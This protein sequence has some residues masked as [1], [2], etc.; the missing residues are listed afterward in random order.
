[1]TVAHALSGGLRDVFRAPALILAAVVAMLVMAVPFGMTVGARVQQSLAHRQPVAHGA[2][3]IDAEWW[4]QFSRHA[5]G[6][7]VT[8]TPSILGFAA[9]LDNLSSL[10]DGRRRPLILLV[11]VAIAMVGWAF[12]WGA[13]LDRF[14]HGRRTGMW[15]AGTRMLVPYVVISG[16][17]AAVVVLLYYTAHPLLFRVLGDRVAM[18]IA[19]ERLAFGF[20]LLLYMLFGSLLV[21]VSIIA[22]YARVALVLSSRP[23]PIIA[24]AESW[25]FA[26][27]H[28]T[29]ACGLHLAAGGLSVLVLVAYAAIEIAGGVHVGGWRG[30]AIAQAYLVARIVVR[31]AFAASELR[32]YRAR[33]TH[34]MRGDE[35]VAPDSL[36]HVP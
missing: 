32:L 16:L 10:L 27:D 34:D 20:R 12:I 5:D 35:R 4:Q 21:A 3:E 9:P 17:A 8:F 30:I 2:T 31:L 11:P 25:R 6:L 22:D 24:I 28:A 18:S 7:A 15:R 33:V 29:A 14:A 26:R 19:D 23:K 1:M 13:A 36:A